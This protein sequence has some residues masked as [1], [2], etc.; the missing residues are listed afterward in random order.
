MGC[1]CVR[2][3]KVTPFELKYEERKNEGTRVSEYKALERVG[4]EWMPMPVKW[5]LADTK[6]A[7][8]WHTNTAIDTLYDKQEDD[9]T[10]RKRPASRTWHL[11][12]LTQGLP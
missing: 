3:G 6:L 12:S 10:H 4:C 2:G 9:R 1:V 5:H 8:S 11:A 7:H